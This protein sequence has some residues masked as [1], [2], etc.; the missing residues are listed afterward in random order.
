ML[1][2]IFSFWGGSVLLVILGIGVYVFLSVY[3][4]GDRQQARID[5]E[6]E[7][8]YIAAM[9]KDTYGGKT[10]QETF[11]MF[12]SA[13]KANDADLAAK[14]FMLDHN[15]SRENWTKALNQL[16]LQGALVEMAESIDMSSLDIE[17]NK[18]SGVWKISN[19]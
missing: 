15:S 6:L 11:V 14:Y 3:T 2:R 5:R 19:L 10:P 8:K 13:L 4:V 17:F 7:Q 9:T 18:Y 16:K 1:K 12:V